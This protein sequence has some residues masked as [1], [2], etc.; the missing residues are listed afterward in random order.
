MRRIGRFV[1]LGLVLFFAAAGTSWGAELGPL[2]KSDEAH[3]DAPKAI[4]FDL[5]A[6][7]RNWRERIA[8]IKAQGTLPVI[9]IE[10]SFNGNKL[11]LRQFAQAMD[12]AGIALIAFSH[13]A[14]NPKWAD[15]AARVVSAD[16]WRFIPTTNGGV[17]PA[18][19]EA[20]KEFLAETFKHAV[21]DGYPLL[22]EFEFRHYPSPRQIQRREFFRDVT[23]PIN[24]PLGQELFAFAEKT[25]LP[26]EI[27]YEIEDALLPP[28]EEMLGRYPKAKVIWCHLA[29]IRYSARSSIYGPAYLRG[30]LAK[31]PNLYI[32][33][34]FG[35]NFSKYPGSDEYHA[36]VWNA[37]SV[38]KEWVD[39][40]VEQ[41]WRFLAAFDLGGDRQDQLPEYNR[42]LR[43][44][45]NQIP[46]PAR[47]IVAYK[48]AWKLLFGEELP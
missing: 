1:F 16:P 22:G 40:I 33:V 42:N 10:S 38:K 4:P 12:K 39:L 46:E 28:L 35:D 3:L 14:G 25:G 13:D 9:D 30:L 45:L 11:P 48:A 18:W 26:F 20:P 32:D 36:R 17:H 43:K 21:P 44:F 37:G 27:H 8:A 24:G 6:L 5:P 29:Q 23:V 7:K 31:Y 2:P 15:I 47:E 34:A 19:T 41:P